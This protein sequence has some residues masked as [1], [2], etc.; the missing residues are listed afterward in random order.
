MKSVAD[1][2]REHAAAIYECYPE[3][4]RVDSVEID[5]GVMLVRASVLLPPALDT[6]DVVVTTG[7]G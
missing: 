5:D 6:I 2:I 3:R 4:I 7:F 1:L